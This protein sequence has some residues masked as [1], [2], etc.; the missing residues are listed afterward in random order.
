MAQSTASLPPRRIH[1]TIL[2]PE[3]KEGPVPLRRNI[4]GPQCPDY[5]PFLL[6]DHIDH[7]I[8][9]GERPPSFG[10]HPHRG[11]ETITYIKEGSVSHRDA[12]GGKGVVGESEVQFMCAG[13]GTVHDERPTADPTTHRLQG[14]QIW[15]ALPSA[16]LKIDPSYYDLH[17]AEIP[18]VRPASGVEVRVITG[19][20]FGSKATQ[21]TRVAMHFLDIRLEPKAKI[22]IP[23]PANF[24]AFA[25]VM[26]GTPTISGY[27]AQKFETV[28][29]EPEGEGVELV[30]DS[31]ETAHVLLLSGD[32][33]KG[34]A[35]YRNGPFV[36]DTAQGARQ[37]GTDF[38]GRKNGFED[39]DH[40]FQ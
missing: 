16:D 24:N 4:G 12:S 35:V 1:K 19:E 20:A 3:I 13:R 17:A 5:M 6:L 21:R 37:A 15:T 14:V 39:V 29:F 25:H 36:S 38:Y 33:L 31:T 28:L 32:P 34:Q 30:N 8:N 7:N 2:L 40:M 9:G 23:V 10:P 27:G 18:V 26:A 22:A 11:Q